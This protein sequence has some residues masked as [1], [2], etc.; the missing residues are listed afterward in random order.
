[1]NNSFS[2]YVSNE[3]AQSH[4]SKSTRLLVLNQA[5]KLGLQT[6][7]KHHPDRT[8]LTIEMVEKPLSLYCL[9]LTQLK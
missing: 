7:V 1:M 5:V 2:A 9:A 4:I 3:F 8:E 6:M